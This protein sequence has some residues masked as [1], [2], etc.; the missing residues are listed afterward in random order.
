ML[1]SERA[2]SLMR[3]ELDTV[4]LKDDGWTLNLFERL[5]SGQTVKQ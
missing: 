2:F 1:V 5:H 3:V 4:D